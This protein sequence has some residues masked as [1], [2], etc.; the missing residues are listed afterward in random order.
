MPNERQVP[1]PIEE[2]MRKSYL[3]YAMSVIVGRALPDIRD[4]L[5][6]VHR[7]VL[8]AMQEL[9]LVSN[10]AYQKAARVVGE[11]LGKYH[12]HGDSPVYEALVRMVQEF[13][14]RYPLVDGQG[15]FGS[16]D[17]DPPAAMRYTEV[18]LA[19]IAH[20]MLADI[21]RDTVDVGEHLVGD[22]RQTHFRVAHRRGRVAV[23]RAEVPLPVDE[24]ITER[25]LL[26]HP[27]QRLIDGRVAVGVVLPE[28]LTDDARRLLVGAVRDEPELLHGVE[29][30]PVDGLEAVADV[31]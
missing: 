29:H 10:R 14:L 2:E 26:D 17:G 6:P 9:G 28:H 16:I 23:D 27:D 22:L 21:D 5:K 3:A 12:P 1:V 19:K 7:R 24:R 4:G 25:E 20:E 18:R 11:V 8:Y 13:S 30:P 31:R 15:N